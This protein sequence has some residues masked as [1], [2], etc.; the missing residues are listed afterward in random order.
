MSS[1]QETKIPQRTQICFSFLRNLR[2]LCFPLFLL[3]PGCMANLTGVNLPTTNATD[4][5]RGPVLIHVPGTAGDTFFDRWFTDGVQDG[6]LQV[7]VEHYEWT[8]WKKRH[9]AAIYDLDQNRRDA[10]QL[11]ERITE[12]A[13]DEPDR[14]IIITSESG[15]GAFSAFALEQLPPDVQIQSWVMLAP[16]L[17]PEYDLSAALKHVRGQAYVFT[18]KVDW[19][20]L[21]VGTWIF[22]TLDRQHV[23]AAGEVGF[24]MPPSGEPQQYAKIVTIPYHWSW[25]RY[26]YFGDHSGGLSPFFGRAIVAPILETGHV[27]E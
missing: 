22:G 12:L 27:P 6:G 10:A 8:T 4:L 13:R 17:S 15:G 11:A 2:N 5:P 18:N 25:A 7:T 20:F 21:G 1:E 14:P 26:G 9:L 3:L 19:L 16:A 24:T 23:A